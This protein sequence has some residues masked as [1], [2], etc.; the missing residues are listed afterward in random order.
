MWLESARDARGSANELMELERFRSCMSRAYYAAYS[1]VT[2]ELVVT[3]GLTMPPDREGPNHPG[4]TGRAGIRRLIEASMP[5]MQQIDPIVKKVEHLLKQAETRGIHLKVSDSKLDDGWLYVV[6]VPKQPGVR[7]S[8]HAQLMS[9]I[10][11]QL[12]AEGD[13]RVLLI[14]ALE[15]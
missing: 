5:T 4:K 14:P 13:R 12:R 10:E 6:V 3:A 11:R 15:D 7:A 2:H 1:K 8:D 9:Q